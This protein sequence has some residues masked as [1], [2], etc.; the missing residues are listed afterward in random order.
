[1]AWSKGKKEK[2]P[3]Y[4]D[5]SLQTKGKEYGPVYLFVGAEDFLIDECIHSIIGDLLTPDARSFNLDMLD[6]EKVGVKEALA[7]AA[8][9]PM[10]SE[11]RI[12]V[13]KDF[14]AMAGSE[15]ARSALSAY[16]LKPLETTCLVLLAEK[17]DF[18]TKPFNELKKMGVVFEFAPFYDDRVPGWI[19]SRCGS[20]GMSID[21]EACRL[22]HANAGNS[23]RVLNNELEKLFTYLS[24]RKR[25]TADD[26]VHVVGV[27]RGNSIFDLQNAI[28]RA[29]LQKSLTI[30]QRM[31]EA[32]ESPQGIIVM[33]TRYF[34]ALWK[35]Q[36]L[37]MHGTAENIIAGEVKISPY[38]LKEYLAASQKFSPGR[39]ESAFKALLEADIDLKSTSPDPLACMTLMIYSC[40]RS[41]NKKSGVLHNDAFGS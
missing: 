13:I 41:E 36:E 24:D 8:A 7:H 16:I 39:F 2:Y 21:A 14:D 6:G 26:I 1:M 29:D 19:E 10:M 11:R 33:L 4:A 27:T 40:A 31:I 17:P 28:G 20:F 5:F 18:R 35:I 37:R 34:S 30:L 23:L 3:S 9:Y 38:F 15:A 12:V 32:G 25:I 22:L